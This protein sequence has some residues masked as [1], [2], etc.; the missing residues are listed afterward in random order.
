M[1]KS[2]PSYCFYTPEKL[3]HCLLRLIPKETIRS[4]VDISCGQGSLLKA[5]HTRYPD[6]DL[7]GADIRDHGIQ[8]TLH[9]CVFYHGDGF[10]YA[11]HCGQRYDLILSNPPFGQTDQRSGEPAF[12]RELNRKR[13]E[14]QM[15]DA[16]LSLM[17][18]SSWLMVIL[19]S[20][21]ITGSSYRDIRAAI[22]SRYQ[23]H[24]IV[25]LPE[26]TFGA[27]RIRTYA[28]ILHGHSEAKPTVLYHASYNGDWSLR[29]KNSLSYDSIK[30]GNWCE[31]ANSAPRLEI[32]LFRG[33]VSSRDFR[34]MGIPVYHSAGKRESPWKPSVRYA[35]I[36]KKPKKIATIGDVI[37][38]RVGHSTGYW[39]VNTENEYAITDCLFVMRGLKDPAALLEQ[40]SVDGRLDIPPRGVA[41]PFITRDDVLA[42]L[43]DVWLKS[44]YS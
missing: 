34:K 10:V 31:E 4:V 25:C 3:A 14:C 23:I 37:I 19:P 7:Y 15:M 21:F 16:N 29:E 36:V 18:E 9:S 43:A 35:E 26:D 27:H 5:A 1:A 11:K 38:N 39:W 30:S 24:S 20:T 22:G 17:H 6:A 8:D 44:E 33:C 40:I 28:V 41:T 32:E 13:L 42:R 2:T 12:I